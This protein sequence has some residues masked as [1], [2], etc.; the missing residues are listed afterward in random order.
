MDTH[1]LQ[2]Q[3]G[4]QCK[5]I[6]Y[7]HRVSL[8]GHKDVMDPSPPYDRAAPG[9]LRRS[10]RGARSGC[11]IVTCT[12]LCGMSKLRDLSISCRFSNSVSRLISDAGR[13][14]YR[15]VVIQLKSGGARVERRDLGD[16]VVFSLTLLLLELER[17]AAN[18]ATL[19][20]LHEMG[21]ETGDLVPETLGGDDGLAGV[22]RSESERNKDSNTDDFIDDTLVGVEV[23]REAW[24]AGPTSGWIGRNSE[25]PL[26]TFQ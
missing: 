16:V 14:T 6:K 18:G 7:D 17:D 11:A 1:R 13:G 2:N 5:H 9:T 21:R 26:T 24:V 22:V 15:S 3:E 12:T 8:V 4:I 20:A 19:D 10:L 23:E 25:A